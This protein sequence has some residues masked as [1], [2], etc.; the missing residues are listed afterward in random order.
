MIRLAVAVALAVLAIG[1]SATASGPPAFV[2]KTCRLTAN[3]QLN[4]GAT[5]LVQLTVGA[6]S[7]STGLQVE[8][9]WQSCRRATA[10]RTTCRKRVL[11]YASTQTI[12]DSNKKQYDAR[13]V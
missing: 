2:A 13:V 5:Y 11:G 10:G 8:K 12:L 6:V 1:G 7:C 9:A 4:A 3:Q